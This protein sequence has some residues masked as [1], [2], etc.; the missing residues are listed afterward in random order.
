MDTRDLRAGL[1]NI[2][3]RSATID[4]IAERGEGM[5]DALIPLLQDR[6][7]GVRWSAIRLLS[8]IGN[9]RAVAPLI[10]L[11]EQNKNATDATNA[12][13]AITGYDLGED[14]AE[15]RRTVM[16]NPDIRNAGGN[17]ILSDHELLA[18]ATR[19]LTATVSGQ[20]AEYRVDVALPDRRSQQVWVDFS[21]TDSDGNAIVQLLTPCGDADETQYEAALKL[22]MSIPY[23]AIALALL[24]DT[25]TFAMVDAYLRDTVHPED[26]ARSILSLA[27]Q[28]DAVERSLSGADRY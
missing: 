4:A 1:R 21:Q 16:Q 13:R 25:L 20:G 27:A 10:T 24:G 19:D 6:H 17:G 12:L 7:E 9:P 11:L 8:E 2:H 23:G 28:G 15:W 18:A 22:N 3:T 26:M 14:P 5:T